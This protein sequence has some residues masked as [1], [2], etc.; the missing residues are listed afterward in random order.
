MEVRNI[1]SG[2]VAIFPGGDW[3]HG[4]NSLELSALGDKETEKVSYKIEV[5]TSDKFGA[6][7]D[8]NVKLKLT[9]ENG[10]KHK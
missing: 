1:D 3:V 9:G 10:I 5:K 2:A 7:T 6:G 4:S 8:A